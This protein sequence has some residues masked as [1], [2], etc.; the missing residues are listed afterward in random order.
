METLSAEAF[1][2]FFTYY[3]GQKNQ[4]EAV[5][6]LRQLVLEVDGSLMEPDAPWILKYR[7]RSPRPPSAR[8]NVSYQSQLDNEI[9]PHRTCFSSSVAMAVMFHLPEQ[10]KSDEDYISIRQRFGDSTDPIAHLHAVR[11]IGLKCE[12]SQGM[13][14]ADLEDLIDEGVPV[15]CG[16][17]HK[18]TL[19]NP[20]GGHWSCCIGYDSDSFLHMDPYGVCNQTTGQYGAKD[21]SN[22]RYSRSQ[23]AN[24]RWQ[25]EG[26]GTGWAMIIRP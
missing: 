4:I 12:Y 15:P 3:K 9:G 21:G 17:L 13:S 19:S 10:F 25:V 8:L 7:A 26:P 1:R 24:Q 22:V 14:S 6:I 11:S 2:N 5:E 18:G 16:W 23:W 20:S